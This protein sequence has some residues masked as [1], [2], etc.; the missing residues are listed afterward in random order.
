MNPSNFIMQPWSCVF[1][2]SEY[3]TV[4]R[5]IMLILKRTGNSFRE[6]SF[7]EYEAE[8]LKDGNYSSREKEYFDKVIPYC[9]N[10][11]EASKFSKTWAEVVQNDDLNKSC[12]NCGTDDGQDCRYCIRNSGLDKYNDLNDHWMPKER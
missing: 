6:L 9:R 2:Y 4:A 10:A 3:E 12:D 8:R 7:E 11:E 5:N 1:G